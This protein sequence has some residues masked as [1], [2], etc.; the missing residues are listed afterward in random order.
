MARQKQTH[1]V[2]GHELTADNRGSEGRCKVCDRIRWAER[3]SRLAAAAL[4]L[5]LATPM[6][7]ANRSAHKFPKG[8]KQSG[9]VVMLYVR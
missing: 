2:R 9:K 7:F 4:L 3:V 6:V 8:A 5:L 1:C